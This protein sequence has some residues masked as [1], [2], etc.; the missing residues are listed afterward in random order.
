MSAVLPWKQCWNILVIA[1]SVQ[2][3]S[4]GCLQKNIKL[5]TKLIAKCGWT[6]LPH[7]PYSPDL[8]PSDFHL[9]GPLKDGLRGEHFQDSDAV[10][11]AVRKWLD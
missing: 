3:G 8:A 2:D 4:H 9:F 10:V 11:K 5:T 6:A 7:P 1:K